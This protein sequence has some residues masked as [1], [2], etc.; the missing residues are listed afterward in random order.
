MNIQDVL[1]NNGSLKALHTGKRCFIIGNGPSTKLQDLTLLKDEI[2]IAVNSFYRHPDA[3]TINPKYWV[4]ADPFCW[5]QPSVLQPAMD[6][7]IST[8]LFVTTAGHCFFS[9]GRMG[10]LIDLHYIHYDTAKT[11]E[12]PI[13][14]TKGV[15]HFGHNVIIVSLML[16]LYLGCDPIYLIGCDHDFMKVTKDEY[17]IKMVQHFYQDPNQ[18]KLCEI[19]T[20]EQWSSVIPIMNLEYGLLKSYASQWGFHIINATNGGYLEAFSRASYE[21]LFHHS[22]DTGIIKDRKEGLP[23][24]QQLVAT[25]TPANDD[26]RHLR[27]LITEFHL[28]PPVPADSLQIESIQSNGDCDTAFDCRKCGVQTKSRVAFWFGRGV[29]C[30]SCGITNFIDPFQNAF[31]SPDEFFVQLPADPIIALWGAGGIYYKLI[32]KYDL[33]ASSRFLLVDADPSQWGLIVCKKKIHPPNI[34]NER[35]IKSVIITALSC[36]DDIYATIRDRY[37]PVGNILTPEITI[38][39]DGIIPILKQ[40]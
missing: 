10:P 14:F 6:K 18:P 19:L 36:K 2:T 8:K 25:S 23:E 1:A 22:Y 34:I 9:G 26:Y 32:K 16:A 21:S 20:W 12:D 4:M 15:P 17:Q 38:T 24:G 5:E 37:P 13:D 30:P 3:K 28:H 29:H 39:N 31:H 7:S 11:I 33:F 27:S 40:L 35:N